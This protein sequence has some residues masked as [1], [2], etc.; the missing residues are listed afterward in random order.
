[1][2]WSRA[3]LGEIIELKYG[4]SL[5]KKSRDGGE[6]AVYGSNG[7]VGS[8]SKALTEGPT[9][10]VGRKGSF[11]EVNYSPEPCSPIDTT[12][13][14]DEFNGLEVGFV[15]RMLG[16]LPLKSLNRSSA[17]P[18]LNREDAYGCEVS[19]APLNEQRRIVTKLEACETRIDAAREA[20]DD[21]PALLEQY[22]Q[23]V[24]A[25]AFCGDLTR[26]W[27]E[28]NPDVE[29]ASELLERLH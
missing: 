23:S 28:S 12:Y 20:L 17:I 9:I 3:K 10:I 24:L 21:V 13:Y 18:G 11:G 22:R 29:P 25:A 1:M 14:I 6:Y 2:K 26:E 8:H 15:E 5:P 16:Q 27:R 4:K 7:K 19:I